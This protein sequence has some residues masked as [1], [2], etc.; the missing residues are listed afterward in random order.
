M[1]KFNKNNKKLTICNFFY[2]NLFNFKKLN[3]NFEK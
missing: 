3:A 1:L 2:K